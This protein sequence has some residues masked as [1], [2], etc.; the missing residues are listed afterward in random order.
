M[1]LWSEISI[2]NNIIILLNSFLAYENDKVQGPV[3]C[4]FP[5]HEALLNK[6]VL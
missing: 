4:T 6:C 2:F 5:A 3:F 1:S